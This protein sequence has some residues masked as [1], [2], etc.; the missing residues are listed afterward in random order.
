M[1]TPSRNLPV[2]AFDSYEPIAEGATPVPRPD[3]ALSDERIP[4]FSYTDEEGER[5]EVTMPKR[6]N[7]GLALNFLR[8]A[9]R[10]GTEL[11]I[12]WLIEE[13][14]GAEG[15]DALVHELSV[16]PDPENGAKVVASIGERVQQVVMGG[17]EGPKA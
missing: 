16:M 11:A 12:S 13:A 7:P 8:T 4:V 6:P 17:L 14:I 10:Q 15:Y 9:R 5:V 2:A 1:S 3:W